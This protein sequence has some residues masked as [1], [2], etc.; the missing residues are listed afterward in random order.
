[1]RIGRTLIVGR[2][3]LPTLIDGIIPPRCVICGTRDNLSFDRLY[4]FEGCGH[5]SPTCET[6]LPKS[7]EDDE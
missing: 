3:E 2:I 5:R 7:D 6:C 1:M 4:N